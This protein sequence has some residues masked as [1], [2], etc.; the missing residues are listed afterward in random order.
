MRPIANAIDAARATA[1]AMLTAVRA[2]PAL[3][4]SFPGA[5][6]RIGG[7]SRPFRILARPALSTCR[8]RPDRM[9]FRR[10]RHGGKDCGI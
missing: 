5:V 2:R 4:D 3:P 7:E 1:A 10:V 9:H 6:C 8:A